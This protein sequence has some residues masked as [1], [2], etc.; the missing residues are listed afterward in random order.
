MFPHHFKHISSQGVLVWFWLGVVVQ[1]DIWKAG[2]GCWIF[3]VLWYIKKGDLVT[4]FCE[5]EFCTPDHPFPW[6]ATFEHVPTLPTL[7]ILTPTPYSQPDKAVS[8]FSGSG[9]QFILTKRTAFRTDICNLLICLSDF[10]T[11]NSRRRR[12]AFRRTHIWRVKW[13]VQLP[14]SVD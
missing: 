6:K 1:M 12:D 11:E 5:D 8:S 10:W 13:S 4:L 3:S 2:G 9:Y 14:P 7:L